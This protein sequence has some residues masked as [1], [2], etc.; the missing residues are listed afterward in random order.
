[1]SPGIKQHVSKLMYT[2]NR[3]VKHMKNGRAVKYNCRVV[4]DHFCTLSK[5]E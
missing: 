4:Q 2:K 5:G 3:I 1:M